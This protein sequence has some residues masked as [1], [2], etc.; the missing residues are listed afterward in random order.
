M[1][2]IN[3]REERLDKKKPSINVKLYLITLNLILRWNQHLSAQT[4][5]REKFI[6]GF[7]KQNGSGYG[8]VCFTYANRWA[9]MMDEAIKEGKV[10]KDIAEELSR[11][12]DIEGISGTMYGFVVNMLSVCWIHGE[13][14]RKWH[15]KDYGHEGDGV[16]NPAVIPL[17]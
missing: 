7:A 12:A 6:A 15:N 11:T 10:V 5:Q 16:V 1:F 4:T 9:T 13:E 2:R 3:W 14:L 8:E 17:S